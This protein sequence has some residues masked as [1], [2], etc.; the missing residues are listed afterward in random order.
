MVGAMRQ[1]GAD[2][3]VAAFVSARARLFGIAYRM[4]GSAAE[5]DDLLQDV[6]LRWQAADRSAVLSPPAFL[7][8]TTT[9]LAL[10]LA[11]CARARHETAAGSRL[12]EPLDP[13]ADAIAL[14]D[15]GEALERALLVLMER[16]SPKER[17]AYV[18]R[19]AFAYEYPEIARVLQLS[20]ANTR[21]LVTRARKHIADERRAQA[22]GGDRRRLLAAFLLA[23]QTGDLTPLLGVFRSDL[24]CPAEAGGF[25][26]APQLGRAGGA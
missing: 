19:E 26:I 6:W 14:A 20:Q 13:G 24:V 17:A 1:G 5:A 15:R 12:P 3:G 16:L 18:L 22:H 23:V 4:L 10:N 25:V 21:Q 8:T 2:D 7:V 9:R 11:C